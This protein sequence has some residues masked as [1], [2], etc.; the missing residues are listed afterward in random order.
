MSTKT[1]K[2]WCWR[3]D[4]LAF[5]GLSD[6][7]KAAF[8]ILLEWF[9]NF[10]LRMDLEAGREA[11]TIFWREEVTGHGRKRE[12]WQ[13]DQWAAAVSWYLN[14][15]EACEEAGADH[16]SVPDRFLVAVRSACARRGLALR[17]KVC[18]GAWA[19]RYAAFG[20]DER[21]RM[22]VATASL[23]LESVVKDEDCAY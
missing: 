17:T 7:D 2:G 21:A 4:L 18:Y 8:L 3:T 22:R 16:R 14:W 6:R 9:E 11:A 5:R 1:K 12:D 15:L 20:G 13:L 19:A 10:R 23:F